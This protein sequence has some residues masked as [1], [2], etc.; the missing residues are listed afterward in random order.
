MVRVRVK[1]CGVRTPEEAVLAFELG[2][3]ALGFN[4]WPGSPRYISPDTAA[5]IISKLAPFVTCVGVF[6]DEPRE[7]VSEI[8]ERIRLGTVQLHGDES[9]EFCA[10]LAPLKVIKALRVGPDFDPSTASDYPASAIL[11][12]ARVH[13]QYGGTG[14]SFGWDAAIA[15][16]DYAQI[17]LAGGIREENVRDAIN[18]VR[19]MAIDVCSG[20]ESEPGRKD[21][22]KLERFMASVQA[23]NADLLAGVTT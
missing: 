8:A 18:K 17:I 7:A 3:D 12:D 6:V 19:P 9:P 22:R 2:A 20:V 1:I 13:G 11:L 14:T 21:L 5:E 10:A 4:F 16:K 15:A 23:A